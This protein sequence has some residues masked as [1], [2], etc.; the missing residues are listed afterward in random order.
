MSLLLTGTIAANDGLMRSSVTGGVA[1]ADVTAP[2]AAAPA[3]EY[4]YSEYNSLGNY[5]VNQGLIDDPTS[6]TFRCLRFPAPNNS[7]ASYSLMYAEYTGAL[8][9]RT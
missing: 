6:H 2:V 9:P 8:P 4:A 3:R 5:T 7:L 1:V